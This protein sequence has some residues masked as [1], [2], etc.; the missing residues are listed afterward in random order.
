MVRFCLRLFLDSVFSQADNRSAN[1]SSLLGRSGTLNLGSTPPAR[2]YL[3][4]VFRISGPAAN[5][6]DR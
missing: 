3:R 4:M 2:R 5:L 1:G 6:P